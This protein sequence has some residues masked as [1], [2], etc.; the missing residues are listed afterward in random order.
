M[1][2]AV[3]HGGNIPEAGPGRSDLVARRV[4][5]LLGNATTLT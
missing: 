2:Q 3:E 1:L 5:L 4:A